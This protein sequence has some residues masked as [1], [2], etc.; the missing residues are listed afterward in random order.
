MTLCSSTGKP[1]WASFA[2]QTSTLLEE[3]LVKN[4]IST[5]FTQTGYEI[6]GAGN[7]IAAEIKGAVHVDDEV[8][9]LV[10]N[11]AFSILMPLLL[12]VTFL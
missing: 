3:L 8:L 9:C 2:R 6:R 12:D 5:R 1:I 11:T 4:K 10:K 7:N